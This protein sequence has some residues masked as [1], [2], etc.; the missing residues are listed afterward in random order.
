MRGRRGKVRLGLGGGAASRSLGEECYGDLAANG[1]GARP[2]DLADD[3]TL[4]TRL[5]IAMGEDD[6]DGMEDAARAKKTRA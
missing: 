2:V 3:P 1:V 4:V 6:E 5:R